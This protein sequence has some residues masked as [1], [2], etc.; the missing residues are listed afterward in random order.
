MHSI[1]SK[2]IEHQQPAVVF[3]LQYFTA[4]TV[5]NKMS[6]SGYTK[7]TER[8]N[9]TDLSN[10]VNLVQQRLDQLERDN[11]AELAPTSQRPDEEPVEPVDGVATRLPYQK[12]IDY[13]ARNTATELDQG[14]EVAKPKQQQLTPTFD[15]RTDHLTVAETDQLRQKLDTAQ[16]NKGVLWA[17]VISFS[18]Q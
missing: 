17:G 10:D 8:D 15:Q 13:T 7:Y 14:D 5:A 12:F 11:L 1:M 6:Y 18:T 3:R 4:A 16:A 2:P 9:A